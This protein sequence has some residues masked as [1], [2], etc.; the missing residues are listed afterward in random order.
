MHPVA[1]ALRSQPHRLAQR[2]APRDLPQR[3]QG[4]AQPRV[5]LPGAVGGRDAGQGHPQ[6]MQV[7]IALA[8]AL[9]GHLGDA[10]QIGR[11]GRLCLVEVPAFENRLAVDRRGTGQ[12]H[13]LQPDLH[14]GVERIDG[15]HQIDIQ[16]LPRRHL[17]ARLR[18]GDH[19]AVKEMGGAVVA[20][21]LRKPRVANIAL[22]RHE[23]TWQAGKFGHRHGRQGV[24]GMRQDGATG[25]QQMLDQT[26][27]DEAT[28]T[29]DGDHL[30]RLHP[31]ALC[32][33]HSA[34]ASAWPS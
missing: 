28:A 6:A 27:T 15:A 3:R 18:G 29:G 19:R 17:L 1:W 23:P 9:D 12:H 16:D 33:A 4:V 11:R 30:R 10:I 26:Q 25:T 14:A 7:L 2:P 20:Q 8:Q 5:A 13:A 34:R 21:A 22:H 24:D 32:R 31:I